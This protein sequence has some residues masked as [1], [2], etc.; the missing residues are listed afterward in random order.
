MR[1]NIGMKLEAVMNDGAVRSDDDEPGGPTGSIGF[2]HRRH[3]LARSC[4]RMTEG[5][6]ELIFDLVFPK[7]FEALASALVV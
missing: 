3:M 2:H 7:A 6:V 5:N 4:G 1:Q